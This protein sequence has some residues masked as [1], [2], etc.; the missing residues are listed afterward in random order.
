MDDM[1]AICVSYRHWPLS[2]NW[3]T[4]GNKAFE[5]H[6]DIEA[7]R[8]EARKFV[9]ENCAGWVTWSLLKYSPAQAITEMI[10]DC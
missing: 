1:N 6:L 10:P 7:N 3:A 8:D 9:N 5:K 2:M 4:S